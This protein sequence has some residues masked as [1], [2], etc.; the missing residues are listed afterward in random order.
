[1]VLASGCHPQDCH[2]LTGQHHAER[3][4]TPLFKRLEGIGISPERF[5]LEWIS[6][7]EGDKYARVIREMDQTLKE[8]GQK[9][10]KEENSRAHPELEKRL[11]HITHFS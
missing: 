10:I 8:I 2:Y 4:L 7:S 3:R 11:S 1:M 5:R 6:A 9:R